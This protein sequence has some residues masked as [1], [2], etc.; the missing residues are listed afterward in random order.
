MLF[1]FRADR[2]VEI[3]KAFEYEDFDAFDRVRFPK[4]CPAQ[5]HDTHPASNLF[6]PLCSH[7]R[8]VRC[9]CAMSCSE[10]LCVCKSLSGIGTCITAAT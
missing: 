1:N 7:T 8:G 4:V 10:C 6:S 9:C 3:S 2:M 5:P